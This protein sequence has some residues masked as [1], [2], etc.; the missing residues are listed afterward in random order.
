LALLLYNIGLYLLYPIYRFLAFFHPGLRDFHRSRKV[1]AREFRRF[2]ST[3][4]R[5]RKLPGKNQPLIW[6]HAASA[7]E[8][9]QAMALIRELRSRYTVSIILSVFSR[10]VKNLPDGPDFS[11]YLP[12]DLPH[13]WPR[14]IRRLPVH[15]FITNTWDVFPNLLRYLKKRGTRCYLSSGALPEKSARIKY[16][17]FFAPHY[18]T[19]QAI[20][21]VDSANAER[22][23]R[24]YSGPVHVTGDTRYDTIL[25]KLKKAELPSKY[26]QPFLSLLKH[27]AGTPVKSRPVKTELN[28]KK[29]KIRESRSP[30]EPGSIKSVGKEGAGSKKTLILASTYESCDRMIFPTLAQWLAEFRNW[31][32]WI[33]PHHIHAHRVAQLYENLGLNDIRAEL[34]TE[35]PELENIPVYR[36]AIAR[37][38]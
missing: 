21:A 2:R 24:I 10:S 28:G 3:E 15:A 36:P 17:W 6:L 30:G 18:R 23:K 4:M 38:P 16:H 27:G 5:M 29:K 1:S 37:S 34:F 20:G 26:R 25:Y 32:V 22:F 12:L 19:L 11:F 14:L 13:V 35:D 8:L 33:F 31:Q 9:D 7:G